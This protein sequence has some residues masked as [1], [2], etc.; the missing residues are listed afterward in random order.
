[1]NLENNFTL[2]QVKEKIIPVAYVL[3]SD[4]KNVFITTKRIKFTLSNGDSFYVPK[5]YRF[6]GTS[7][8]RFLCWF[9]SRLDD[10][11]LGAL[12][13]DRMYFTD[14]K[15]YSLGDKEAKKLADVEMLLWFNAQL[16]KSKFLN[17]AMFLGV[18]YLGWKVFK[19]RNNDFHS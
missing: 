12:I 17:K 16:P 7:I 10:R 14:Y 9:A 6:D 18:K 5:G 15:R 2:T 1:M 19:R 3:G 11:I 13:H 8:P 4:S